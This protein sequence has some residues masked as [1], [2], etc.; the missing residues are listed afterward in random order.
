MTSRRCPSGALRTAAGDASAARLRS[1]SSPSSGGSPCRTLRAGTRSSGI[2]TRGTTKN[3]RMAVVRPKTRYAGSGGA[4]YDEIGLT[5]ASTRRPDPRIAAAILDALGDAR[6]VVNVGAGTGAYEPTDREVVAVEP[7][8]TM[9]AQRP[10]TAAPV[11][12][13]RAEQLPF[14]DQSFDAALAVNTVQHW[15]EVEAGLRELRR[16]ARRRVVIFLRNPSSGPRFWL[17][18]YVP[19]L[20]RTE[21]MAGVVVTIE[22]E[23]APVRAVRVPLP[24]ECADGLFSPFWARPE[25]YLDEEVR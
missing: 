7:S 3:G 18:D 11:L 5:Y 24:R 10:P 15:S 9:I 6:S 22:R 19:A 21:K 12:E 2:A 4:V 17:S 1:R 8:P 20:E 16:V 13:A 25:M 14:A 23:L